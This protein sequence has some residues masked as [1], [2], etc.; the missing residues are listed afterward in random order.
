MADFYEDARPD[1]KSGDILQ[2]LEGL[3]YGDLGSPKE[4]MRSYSRKPNEN[5]GADPRAQAIQQYMEMQGAGPVLRLP[6]KM[7]DAKGRLSKPS[8]KQRDAM[9]SDLDD[10]ETDPHSGIEDTNP[11]FRTEAPAKLEEPYVDAQ[12]RIDEGILPDINTGVIQEGLQHNRDSMHLPTYMDRQG[13]PSPQRDQDE[14]FLSDISRHIDAQEFDPEELRRA[15]DELDNSPTDSAIHN[16]I[17]K[18]GERNLRLPTTEEERQNMYPEQ[19]NRAPSKEKG[20]DQRPTPEL[21]DIDRI[22]RRRVIE[23]RT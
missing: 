18:Y 4:S 5:P 19:P 14:G 21:D 6:F 10:R 11:L 20:T 8:I 1:P 7:P 13:K 15:Q 17:R 16:F 23:Q 22:L 2:L 9:L 3:Q 12:G